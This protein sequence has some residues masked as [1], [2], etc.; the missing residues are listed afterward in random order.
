MKLVKQ[1]HRESRS[2][3]NNAMSTYSE[4]PAFSRSQNR[5]PPEVPSNVYYN[6]GF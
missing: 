5:L 3:V 1:G 6:E 2:Q 4:R